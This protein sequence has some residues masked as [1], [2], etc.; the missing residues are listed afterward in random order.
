MN[1][2][3]REEAPFSVRVWQE[4]DQA[5]ATIRA[6][7]GTARRFLTVDGPYGL[8]LTSVAGDE[9]WRRPNEVGAVPDQWNVRRPDKRADG[10]EPSRVDPGTYLVQGTSRPVPLIASEFRLGIRNVEAFE[11]G[12]QPLDVCR[13]TQA[14]RDVALEEERLIYYG[15]DDDDESLLR[16]VPGVDPA[17]VVTAKGTLIT[18]NATYLDPQAVFVGLHNAILR[19]A[20]RGYAGPFALT[21]EPSIYIAL[22]SPA[23]E[24]AAGTLS[25]PILL[26]DLLRNMFRGGIFMAPV[27][28]SET[29][30]KKRVG[31]IVTVGR[32]Y[33]RLVVGQDWV[34]TYRSRDGVLYRFLI[35]NSL[36]LRVCDPASI[37]VLSANEDEYGLPPSVVDQS[38][39]QMVTGTGSPSGRR[40]G[41]IQ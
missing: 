29:D 16:I 4:I 25:V 24:T 23:T 37:Q 13:A 14:A 35:L 34:T 1:G 18:E 19:L 3:G 39:T 22:Y 31:A 21:V 41:R 7:N 8:G 2:L 17:G 30:G 28:N 11:A 6:A 10:E 33:S 38:K 12:C 20:A 40:A 15:L 36:Q 27:I 26:V 5:V 32:P 9:G